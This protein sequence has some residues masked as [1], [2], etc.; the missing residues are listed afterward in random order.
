MNR[1]DFFMKLGMGA[2]VASV[3]PSLLAKPEPEPPLKPYILPTDDLLLRYNRHYPLTYDECYKYKED[4]LK[5]K[6]NGFY[7]IGDRLTSFNK[8]WQIVRYDD[9][10]YYA[11]PLDS[12]LY[13]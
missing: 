1:K 8:Q 12:L 13:T 5:I 9:K 10:F 4:E 7:C 3:A 6:R 2:L 11:Y